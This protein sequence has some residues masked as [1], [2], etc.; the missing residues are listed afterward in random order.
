MNKYIYIIYT[1][2][3]IKFFISICILFEVYIARNVDS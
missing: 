3:T 1:Y 2:N